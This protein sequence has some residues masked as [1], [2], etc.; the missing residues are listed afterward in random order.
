M[1]LQH[2]LKRVLCNKLVAIIKKM[3]NKWPNILF[4]IFFAVYLLI[5]LK[6]EFQSIL[7]HN[8]NLPRTQQVSGFPLSLFSPGLY[9]CLFFLPYFLSCLF[10][11]SPHLSHSVSLS[12]CDLLPLNQGW[13][14]MPQETWEHSGKWLFPAR[15]YHIR[16]GNGRKCFYVC[17]HACDF[18]LSEQL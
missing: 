6:F 18:P 4:P 12:L 10:S 8:P 3:N 15:L 16:I 9:H 14:S 7:S 1:F 17:V 13:G 11:N 5:C 2:R